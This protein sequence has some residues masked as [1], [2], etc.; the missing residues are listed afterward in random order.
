VVDPAVP[1]CIG[2]DLSVCLRAA[3]YELQGHQQ[4]TIE[5]DMRVEQIDWHVGRRSALLHFYMGSPERGYSQH[6]LELQSMGEQAEAAFV[7]L[8]TDGQVAGSMPYP[9]SFNHGFQSGPELQEW[10]HVKYV[11][12]AVDSDGS[13]NALRLTVGDTVLADGLLHYGLRYREPELELGVPFVYTGEL[14]AA[15]SNEG[16]QVRYDNVLVVIEPRS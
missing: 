10:V 2:C 5:F 8:D 7:E 12:D 13:G 4:L 11:L 3:F 16:W 14:D 1:N 9:V 15:D 6:L